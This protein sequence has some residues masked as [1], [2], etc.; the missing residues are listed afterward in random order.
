MNDPTP[1]AIAFFFVALLYS[2]VGLGGGTSYTAIL[3]IAGVAQAIIPTTSL[4]LNV[5]VASLGLA[6][7]SR[8]GYFRPKLILPLLLAS[9]PMAFLGGQLVLAAR[10]FQWLLLATLVAVAARIYL[11][12]D[13]HSNLELKAGSRLAACLALGAVLGFVAGTVGIGGGIYLIPLLISLNLASEREAATAGAVF[14]MLNSLAGLLPRAQTGSLEVTWLLP[15]SISV[16][17]GGVIGSHL[18]S[19]R[20]R[21][22]TVQ[23]VLGVVVLLAIAVLLRRLLA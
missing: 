5:I 17:L 16:L 6:S 3:A 9:M 4:A 8:A 23:K 13:L 14:V 7:F 15:L 21:P 22:R 1:F 18:G 12:G 20:F 11:V 10:V 2:S 19:V